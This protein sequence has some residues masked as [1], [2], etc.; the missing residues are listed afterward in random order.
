MGKRLTATEKWFDPWFSELEP[1]HKLFWLFLLD[2]VDVAGLWQ[3][4]IKLAEFSTGVT[5]GT[6]E[7]LINVMGGRVVRVNGRF[8]LPK[9]IEF[10]YGKLSKAS[11]I[12]IR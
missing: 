4:N 11:P 6:E 7:E 12:H 10:Q 8:F 9:F 3:V 1:K 2:S 5:L